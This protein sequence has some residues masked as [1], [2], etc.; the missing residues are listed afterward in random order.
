MADVIKFTPKIRKRK[1]S[2]T[3]PSVGTPGFSFTEE[4]NKDIE[5]LCANLNLSSDK[6]IELATNFYRTYPMLMEYVMSPENLLRGK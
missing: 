1:E 5:K 4:V 2:T 3:R 6:A